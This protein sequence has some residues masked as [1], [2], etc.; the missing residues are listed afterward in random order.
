MRSDRDRG[1]RRGGPWRR[2]RWT[3]G[4]GRADDRGSATVEFAVALPGVVVLLLIFLAGWS[5]SAAKVRL[6]DAA[7][8][9]ARAA[10]RGE[11]ESTA[12]GAMPAGVTIS[13]QRDGDLVRVTV[14]QRVGL[15]PLPS[16]TLREE[17][18]ALVEPESGQP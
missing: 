12:R 7:G 3:F 4:P 10:A 18:V 14:R 9:A 1:V 11:P 15:G 13:V 6:A 16:I 5:A 17:A 8:L 2:R